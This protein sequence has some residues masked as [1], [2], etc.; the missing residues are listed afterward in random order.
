MKDKTNIVI[1]LAGAIQAASLVQDIAKT[2]R[3][4]VLAFETSILSL[5][6]LNP[7]NILEIYG[8]LAG[9]RYGFEQIAII[10]GK[11]PQQ[12]ME[13]RRYFASMIYLE[14]KVSS[15]PNLLRAL[16]KGIQ[17]AEKKAAY[18]TKLDSNLIH[19]FAELYL[20]NVSSLRHRIQILGAPQYL[21][22]KDNLAKIRA[23]LLAGIR[24][25]ILWRQ[26]GGSRLQLIFSHQELKEKAKELLERISA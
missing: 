9:L 6:E 8:G 4:D 23:L 3:C 1:A 11:E 18:F 22:P 12:G 17:D 15:N 24:S 21:T 20:K 2:G 19:F 25:I 10:L 7:S 26:M 16:Q 13:A 14:R 5:Y